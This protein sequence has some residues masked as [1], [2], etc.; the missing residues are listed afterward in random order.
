L[1]LRADANE[2]LFGRPDSGGALPYTPC[3][4]GGEEPKKRE[5]KVEKIEF[6]E[7]HVGYVRA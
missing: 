5:G 1:N 3:F 4:T 2:F 6:L 7:R